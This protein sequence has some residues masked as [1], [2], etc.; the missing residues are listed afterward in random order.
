MKAVVLDTSAFIQGYN[1]TDP[2]TEHYTVPLV[3]SEIRDEIALIRFESALSSGRIVVVTPT[4]ASVRRLEEE[5]R[6]FG[7]SKAL[8]E[9]DKQ[10]LALAV[11]LKLQ[12]REPTVVSDDFSVQ[13]TAKKLGVAYSGR[14]YRITKELRWVIYC[15][16]CKRRFAEPQEDGVCPICGT[17]L[18][19]KPEKP[20]T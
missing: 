1:F 16:G 14:A 4:E 17:E 12:G 10:L 9:T 15:P 8:S 13:N 18:K 11:D 3:R 6:S 19:R 2:A 7:E 5:A 20:R